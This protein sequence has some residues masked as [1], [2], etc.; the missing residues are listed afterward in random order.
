MSQPGISLSIALCTYNGARFLKAQLES[1]SAQNA[2]P[3]ELVVCDDNST[4]ESPQLIEEFAR[5]APFEVLMHRQPQRLG[6]KANREDC[7]RRC[8]GLLIAPSDQDDV[9]MPTK[10][11]RMAKALEASP[12]CLLAFNDCEV[13]DEELRPLGYRALAQ[14]SLK[15]ERQKQI[16]SGDSLRAL[17]P[18]TPIADATMV[19]RASLLHAALPIPAEWLPDEWL[20]IVA[21]A[22]GGC[23]I[24]PEPLQLYRQHHTNLLGA[25]RKSLLQKYRE[26]KDGSAAE[27]F[28]RQERHFEVLRDR[29]ARQLAHPGGPAPLPGAIELVE[30]RLAFTAARR[31]MRQHPFQRPWIILRELSQGNYHRMGTGWRTLLYDLLI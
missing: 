26:S 22:T 6:W 8:R 25:R 19:F 12:Q 18:N 31:R 23:T 3:N 5:S 7:Y 14:S 11:A 30:Q 15:E 10:L 2:L 20:C 9:W 16:L 13:V 1:F 29:L 4:D 17:L 21:A 24:V 28:L 27:Y